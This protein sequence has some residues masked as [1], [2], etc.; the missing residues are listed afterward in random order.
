MKRRTQSKNA[1]IISA[2]AV[3]IFTLLASFSGTF[4]WFEARR[5]ANV[6]TGDFQVVNL[7]ENVTG[8][9]FHE[10][11]GVVDGNY[12]F[13]TTATGSVTID[14][15]TGTAVQ[16][17]TP[18]MPTYSLEYPHQ[19]ILML[20]TVKQDSGDASISVSNDSV[21]IADPNP[22]G[23]KTPYNIAQHNTHPLSSVAK[24]IAFTYSTEED[25]SQNI[26]HNISIESNNSADQTVILENA[27]S[28]F[29]VPKSALD[30]SKKWKS[31]VDINNGEYN[32]FSPRKNIY[33]GTTANYTYI[34]IV[35]EYYSES[36]EY[37]YSY[38]MGNE[39]INEGLQFYC[40]WTTNL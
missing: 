35:V 28:P 29:A 18:T 21:Y 24:F 17:G 36:L 26:T 22:A 19:P 15:A 37:I 31:F 20:L 38:Y 5:S 23:G 30:N 39:S 2:T 3:A 33:T 12:T 6:D 34:G 11:N 7:G 40:D 4:A 10:F 32:G 27:S 9:A 16:A 25:E 1:K 13:K 14:P 8:V